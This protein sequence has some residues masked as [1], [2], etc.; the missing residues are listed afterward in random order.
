[1]PNEPGETP[2]PA[3]LELVDIDEALAAA[4]PLLEV[5]W[6][7]RKHPDAP[8]FSGGVWD[9]WPARDSDV[10]AIARAEEQLIWD[11]VRFRKVKSNGRP[12]SQADR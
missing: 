8:P 7:V 11:L 4:E 10:C 1:V 3:Y 5:W 12:P 2:Q 9:A 6:V